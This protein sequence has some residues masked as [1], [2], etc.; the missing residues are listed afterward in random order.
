MRRHKAFAWQARADRLRAGP[1]VITAVLRYVSA[2]ITV[3]S[4]R[5][6]QSCIAVI[7]LTGRVNRCVVGCLITTAPDQHRRALRDV[8]ARTDFHGVFTYHGTNR[9]KISCAREMMHYFAHAQNLRFVSRELS[10]TPRRQ[11]PTR[12]VAQYPALLRQAD[13]GPTAVVHLRARPRPGPRRAFKHGPEQQADRINAMKGLFASVVLV[14]RKK[15]DPLMDLAAALNGTLF[16]EGTE[17]ITRPKAA[18]QARLRTLLDV[19]SLETRV[20]G[21]WEPTRA[22]VATERAG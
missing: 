20:Q 17:L 3:S 6:I 15:S 13:V 12:L 19:R 5:F 11:V 9:H 8:Y 18:L 16:G 22:T 4:R 2:M 21:K 7:E 14:G 1:V 10:G